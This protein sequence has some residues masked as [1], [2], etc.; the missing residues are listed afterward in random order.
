[1]GSGKT[2]VAKALAHELMRHVEDLDTRIV[3]REN[4]SI[5][6]IFTDS[7]EIYFRKVESEV[8]TSIAEQDTIVVATA[9]VLCLILR[10]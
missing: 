7:G 5:N 9:A 8:L 10:T 4:R 3:E 1:M 2:I 6:S